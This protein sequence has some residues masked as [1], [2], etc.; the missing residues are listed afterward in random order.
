LT[1]TTLATQK[2]QLRRVLRF[3]GREQGAHREKG[4]FNTKWKPPR[5][6]KNTMEK[7]QLAQPAGNQI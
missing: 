7:E 6:K 4:S 2:R 1:A 3:R 5:S